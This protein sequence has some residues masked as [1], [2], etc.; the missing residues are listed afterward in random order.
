MEFDSVRHKPNMVWDFKRNCPMSLKQQ[1]FQ[2][3]NSVVDIFKEPRRR[4]FR[5]SGLQ[6]LYDFCV[7]YGIKDI[8]AMDAKEETKF[9][10]YLAEHTTSN[11]RKELLLPILNY[12]RK[13]LFLQSDEINWDANVVF[14]QAAPSEKQNKSKQ[15]VRQHILCRD[16]TSG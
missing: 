11:T 5:L 2:V 12:C 1:I 16:S 9:E 8:E 3:L 10:Q 13:T 14:R 7:E 4:E 15:L 6:C